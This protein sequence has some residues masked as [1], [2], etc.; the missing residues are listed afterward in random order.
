MQPLVIVLVVVAITGVAWW[1]WQQEVKRRAAIEQLAASKGLMYSR[2]D[3]VGIPQRHPFKLWVKGD[4][5]KWENVVSGTLDGRDVVLFEFQYT[6]IS[7]DSEGKQ[8]RRTYRFQGAIAPIEGAF[9]PGLQVGPENLL[10]RLKDKAGFRDLELESEDFN[11]RFEV[12]ANDRRFAYAFLD[13]RMMNWLLATP[14][15]LRFEVLGQHV[16]VIGDRIPVD[17]WMLRHHIA[18]DFANRT[19]DVVRSLYPLD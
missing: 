7:R 17:Q 9:C 8:Q 1:L 16:M 3:H 5:R 15:G 14:K 2:H 12:E 6:E 11:R 19:P 4:E 13:A 10:T 18:Q